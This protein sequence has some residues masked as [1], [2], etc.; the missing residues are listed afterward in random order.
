MDE[1]QQIDFSK[2]PDKI[3]VSKLPDK[4]TEDKPWYSKAWN[5]INEPLST[6]PGTI[7]KAALPGMGFT[8]IDPNSQAANVG[9]NIA[10]SM[11]SPANLAMAA[12]SGGESL[13]GRAGLELLPQILSYGRRAASL[14]FALEGASNVADTNKSGLERVLGAAELA[15]GVHGMGVLPSFNVPNEKPRI[16]P[17]T[18]ADTVSSAEYAR[19]NPDTSGPNINP[20]TVGPFPQRLL[21]AGPNPLLAL[22]AA[23]E[24]SA[25]PTRFFSGQHGIADTNVNYLKDFTDFAKLRNIPITPDEMHSLIEASGRDP[26]AILESIVGHTPTETDME[27]FLSS[28]PPQE[29]AQY[30]LG[31]GDISM[32]MSRDVRGY[33]LPGSV[34]DQPRNIIGEASFIPPG[35]MAADVSPEPTLEHPAGG[36]VPKS[37]VPARSSIYN[38]NSFDVVNRT[39]SNHTPEGISAHVDSIPEF[40]SGN[41]PKPSPDIINATPTEPVVLSDLTLPR[42]GQIRPTP[43]KDVNLWQTQFNSPH[44]ILSNYPDT[45]EVIDP[46]LQANDEGL[47]WL[48]NIKRKAA[49]TTA[50]LNLEERIAM[51]D[52]AQGKPANDPTGDLT[53]RAGELR[54][55]LDNAH[56]NMP[57]GSRPDGGDVGYTKDYVT[58]MAA[59]DPVVQQIYDY[60]MGKENPL[61]KL[62]AKSNIEDRSIIKTPIFEK[63]VGEPMSP[64]TKERTGELENPEQDLN[65][66][67]PAYFDSIKK[68]VFDKPAVE[69]A[70]QALSNVPINSKRYDLA[71]WTIKNYSGYDAE[72]QLHKSSDEFWRALGTVTARSYFGIKPMLHVL[73]ATAVPQSIWPEL[74]TKYST[75]G[76]AKLLNEPVA[77][78]TELGQRGLVQGDTNPWSFKTP[79]ERMDAIIHGNNYIE[80][81]VKGIGYFGAKQK[82]LDQKMNEASATMKAIQDTKDMTYSTDKIRQM[83]GTSPESNVWGGEGGSQI[84]WQGKRI[85]LKLVENLTNTLMDFKQNKAKAARMVAGTAAVGTLLGKKLYDETS[86]MLAPSGPFISTLHN[87][88]TDAS[89]GDYGSMLGEVL[90]WAFP[91]GQQIKGLLK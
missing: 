53:R 13:A 70:E 55:I 10:N 88:Y 3:D 62:F 85:P 60:Y 48:G 89:K 29:A 20:G 41:T 37:E 64:Y 32:P 5:A 87:I 11:T 40:A 27:G 51:S 65:K 61:Y 18:A 52:I 59:K 76:L 30:G 54:T 26:K 15:G 73:H 17:L 75:I 67:L 47:A 69:R 8:S 63:G 34:T 86:G 83:K 4:P 44:K 7:Y 68:V 46:L 1:P 49:E 23:G 33:G 9:A 57:E 58:R 84:L 14:P 39:L 91:G 78:W 31:K 38:P 24:T 43:V 50:G 77:A 79:G 56:A 16:G 71:K 82:Y 36:I 90:A 12:A 45:K 21:G 66:I 19:L 2:L 74:G 80:K 22:P 6:I 35:G 42:A 28:L 72:P 25:A 81:F